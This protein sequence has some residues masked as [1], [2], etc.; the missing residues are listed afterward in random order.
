MLDSQNPDLYLAPRNESGPNRGIWFLVFSVTTTVVLG[1][2][3]TAAEISFGMSRLIQLLL[4]IAVPGLFFATVPYYCFARRAQRVNGRPQPVVWCCL[5]AVCGSFQTFACLSV[6]IAVT[7]LLSNVFLLHRVLVV[8]SVW[9]SILP[10][11]S[12]ITI[13]TLA[14]TCISIIGRHSFIQTFKAILFKVTL[15]DDLFFCE[16]FDFILPPLTR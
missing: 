7:R 3:I 8:R 2:A 10:V 11:V 9:I 15:I 14:F 4:N 1:I 5:I 16:R 6:A 12:I 13:Y